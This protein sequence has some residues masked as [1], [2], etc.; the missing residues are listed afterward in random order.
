MVPVARLHVVVHLCR[1]LQAF[2][3]NR[4][5]RSRNS[6][7]EITTEKTADCV[8]EIPR[9]QSGG[10]LLDGWLGQSVGSSRDSSSSARWPVKPE[11]GMMGSEA[12]RQRGWDIREHL[13]AV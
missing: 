10:F 11:R 5:R 7:R 6:T 1:T 3:A 2:H 8:G 4:L 12:L 13:Q 9:T